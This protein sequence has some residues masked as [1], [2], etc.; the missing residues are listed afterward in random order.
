MTRVVSPQKGAF[1]PTASPNNLDMECWLKRF[2]R[3]G[4]RH[5][6]RERPLKYHLASEMAWVTFEKSPIRSLWSLSKMLSISAVQDC[7]FTTFRLW[8]NRGWRSVPSADSRQILSQNPTENP[9]IHSESL[10]C[11]P[12]AS[13]LDKA[14]TRAQDHATPAAATPATTCGKCSFPGSAIHLKNLPFTN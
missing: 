10:I 12:S 13:P 5:R 3:A 11:N 6:C 9:R 14:K 1:S 2:A 7:V 4:L 8:G